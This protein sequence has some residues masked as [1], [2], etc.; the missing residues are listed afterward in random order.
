[1]ILGFLLERCA[2]IDPGF[3]LLIEESKNLDS[4]GQDSRYPNDYFYVDKQSTEEA[5]ERAEKI[6]ITIKKKLPS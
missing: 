1:M 6:L 5:I 4:Y 3:M 2:E